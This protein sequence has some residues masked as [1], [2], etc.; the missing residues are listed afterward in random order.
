HRLPLN[1]ASLKKV[2]LEK[3]RKN[4][5]AL[6]ELLERQHYRL[7]YWRVASDEINYRRFFEIADLAALRVEGEEVFRATHAFVARLC[8]RPG[9]DGLRI[10]HPDGLADPHTYVERLGRLC[11]KPW[12][13]VE[14][15][16]A[17]HETLPAGWAVHGTTGYRFANL[18]TGLFV[19]R[20]AESRFDRIYQRFTGEREPFEEIARES[21]M[22]IMGTTLAADL[23][24]LATRLERIAAGN[25]YTRDYTVGGLRR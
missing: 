18:L 21:R 12:I 16:T 6:H 10:D 23:N 25:R 24:M 3:A 13:V 17:G 15:I 4:A 20:E 7:A 2:S 19:D 5:L 22:L 1:E 11:G 14:K 9:V 8:A